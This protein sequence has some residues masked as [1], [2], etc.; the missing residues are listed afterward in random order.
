MDS[1]LLDTQKLAPDWLLTDVGRAAER[2]FDI[3]EWA[4]RKAHGKLRKEGSTGYRS[5]KIGDVND[6]ASAD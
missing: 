5:Q 6:P 3:R 2:N 4:R 1:H